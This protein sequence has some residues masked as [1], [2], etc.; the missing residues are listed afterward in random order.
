MANSSPILTWKEKKIKDGFIVAAG[1]MKTPFSR[2]EIQMVLLL[3]GRLPCLFITFPIISSQFASSK[4]KKT[5]QRYGALSLKR[6]DWI[7]SLLIQVGI[8]V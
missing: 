6:M 3:F 2:V 7:C 5:F 8:Q 1:M 4:L